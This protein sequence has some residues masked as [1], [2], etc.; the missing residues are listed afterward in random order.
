MLVVVGD[1]VELLAQRADAHL[2]VDELEV[3]VAIVEFSG[4]M[5]VRFPARV[6]SQALFRSE[7]SNS[8]TPPLFE[9]VLNSRQAA[10]SHDE[11]QSIS[12]YRRG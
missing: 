11:V 6:C 7:S 8:R 9:S 4:V 2:A 12:S 5:D 3:A 10:E 1:F